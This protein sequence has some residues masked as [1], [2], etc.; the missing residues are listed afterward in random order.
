MAK[1]TKRIIQLGLALVAAPYLGT[2]IFLTTRWAL[3]G[4]MPPGG[5]T[6]AILSLFIG[7]L[8]TMAAVIV[9]IE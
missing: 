9:E 6:R 1:T 4:Y 3:T 7:L 5:D 2:F 8:P